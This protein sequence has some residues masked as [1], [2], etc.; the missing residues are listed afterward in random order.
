MQGDL[1]RRWLIPVAAP[2]AL[3]FIWLV[4]VAFELFPIRFYSA[5][6]FVP[7]PVL[8]IAPVGILLIVSLREGNARLRV[9]ALVAA[10]AAAPV[11]LFYPWTVATRFPGAV[12]EL[13][14]FLRWLTRYPNFGPINIEVLAGIAAILATGFIPALTAV[15]YL[16]RAQRLALQAA[17]VISLIAYVPVLVR[18]D[19][20]LLRIAGLWFE[21]FGYQPVPA[22]GPAI[23]AMAIAAA[24]T[25]A[26][27]PAPAAAEINAP[28]PEL[29]PAHR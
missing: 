26:F 5:P 9:A 6:M 24:L 7:A 12:G 25:L 14:F 21:Q 11:A 20:D 8:I 16:L 10:S 18:L 17:A 28:R 29:R 13:S 19:V 27:M 15:L 2:A 4:S 1:R 22:Y 23:R 3:V